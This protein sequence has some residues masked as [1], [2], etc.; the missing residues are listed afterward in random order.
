MKSEAATEDEKS[1]KKNA[2]EEEKSP[3]EG[4]SSESPAAGDVAE[5]KAATSAAPKAEKKL[6]GPPPKRILRTA[7]WAL[8]FV[9]T[10]FALACILVWGLTPPSGIERGGLLGSIEDIV[11]EQP[12]PVGIVAFT[13]FETALWWLRH[14]FRCT[15]IPR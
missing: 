12:V 13:L 9:L 4:R 6:D 10:P 5:A 11:R 8:W 1:E 7:Y 2:A 14:D 3:S 15:T